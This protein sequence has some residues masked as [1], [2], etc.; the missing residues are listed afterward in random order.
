MRGRNRPTRM[1]AFIPI[2]VPV[3]PI[4]VRAMLMNQILGL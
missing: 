2:Q 3:I 1:N 4:I